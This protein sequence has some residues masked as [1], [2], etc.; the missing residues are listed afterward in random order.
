[1]NIL[2]AVIAVLL[3]VIVAFLVVTTLKIRYLFANVKAF[4][5]PPS[6]NEP[7]PLAGVG[8]ALA[9]M[10]ARSLAAQIKATFMGKQSGD[11]RAE[12]AVMADIAQDALADRMPLAAGILESFPTLKKSLRR[13]PALLDFALSKLAG[14]GAGQAA[15][16][17]NGGTPASSPKFKL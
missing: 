14:M 2:L 6:E 13:N 10:M 1:M 4:L 11:V 8:S 7:S 12:Q 15:N 16:G 5:T 17:G 3:L 9:D